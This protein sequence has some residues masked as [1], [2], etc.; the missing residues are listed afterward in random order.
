MT[1]REFSLESARVAAEHD[2][3]PDWV[4]RFLASAGSDNA[5]LADQLTKELRW[6]RGPVRLPLDELQRLA[7]P[8]G[9][10]VV[11]PVDEQYWDE[12]VHEMEDLAENGWEPP[13]LIVAYRDD[14]LV[15]EDGNHRVESLRRA[16][17]QSAWAVVG[18]SSCEDQ[19]RF[20]DE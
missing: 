3:L 16:G 6:W 1:D 8:P 18:F 20:A 19:D 10:P 5:V 17:R 11:C 14:K 15:L 9:D 7:G 2:Q 4:A 13:P 12:R